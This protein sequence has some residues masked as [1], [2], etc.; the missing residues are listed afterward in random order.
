MGY[1]SLV[2]ASLGHRVIAIEPLNRNLGLLLQSIAR[3]RFQRRIRVFHN[4]VSSAGHRTKLVETDRQNFGNGRVLLDPDVSRY[5]G[6]GR[7]V[8]GAYGRDFVDAVTLDALLAGQAERVHVLKIDVE[9]FEAFVVTG[10][11][12][13]VCDPT[14]APLFIVMELLSETLATAACPVRDVLAFLVDVGYT[15]S[16]VAPPPPAHAPPL[17]PQAKELP[18]NVLLSYD[19]GRAVRPVPAACRRAAR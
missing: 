4:V 18:P 2:A 14:R 3:N 6:E 7:P 15:L 9:G 5:P 17:S 11:V 13:L 19:A 12:S 16:D 8:V 10:A 1:F